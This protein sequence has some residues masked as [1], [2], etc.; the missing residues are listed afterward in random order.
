M[1]WINE[2]FKFEKNCHVVGLTKELNVFYLLY[3]FEKSDKNLL[4][5][6][7]SLYECNQ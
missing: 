2:K 4:V 5:V 1:K 7:N 6:T 3:L